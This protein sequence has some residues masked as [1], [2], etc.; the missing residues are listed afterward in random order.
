M[1][2]NRKTDQKLFSVFNF[3]RSKTQLASVG[4]LLFLPLRPVSFWPLP[5]GAPLAPR[6]AE[7]R[8]KVDSATVANASPQRRF[9]TRPA[10][11]KTATRLVTDSDSVR[12]VGRDPS[13]WR[14]RSDGG[15]HRC[16]ISMS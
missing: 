2:R 13:P 12:E 16:G 1:W 3:P 6:K 9:R 7:P 14:Q 8:F 11:T 5:P 4:F 15:K 10:Y